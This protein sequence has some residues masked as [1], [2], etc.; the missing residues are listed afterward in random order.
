M[1]LYADFAALD[2]REHLTEKYPLYS[3]DGKKADTLVIAKYFFPASAATWYVT[4]VSLEE[5][6]TPEGVKPLPTFF[7][8]VT[9]LVEDELGYFS[10]QE[11]AEVKVDVPVIVRNGVTGEEKEIK[12]PQQIERDLYFTPAPLSKVAPDFCAFLWG[13]EEAPAATEEAAP[14]V[15]SEEAPGEDE[16]AAENE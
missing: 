14:G 11:L 7:G 1:D 2:E 8:L 4:E 15:Q 13:D 5:Y 9:G 16:E 3:Q 10:L 6:D 12:I